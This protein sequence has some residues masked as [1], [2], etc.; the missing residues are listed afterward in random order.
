[1]PQLRSTISSVY[2]I[3]SNEKGMEF[4]YFFIRLENEHELIKLLMLNL[5]Q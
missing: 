3:R 1:M 5:T 4:K 2:T